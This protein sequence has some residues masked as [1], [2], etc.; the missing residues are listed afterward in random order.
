MSARVVP[1]SLPDKG[2]GFRYQAWCPEHSD[3]LNTK[4]RRQAEK[5]R[6]EH[7]AEEH[8]DK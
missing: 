5:W 1:A 7:N 4:T 6:D 3:G 8:S 2:S